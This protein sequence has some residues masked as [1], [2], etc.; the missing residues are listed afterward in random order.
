M[1]IALVG[2]PG[3]GK[4][5]VAMLLE[6]RGFAKLRFGDITDIELKRRGLE[7]NEHNEKSLREELRKNYGMSAYAQLLLPLIKEK[8]A[9][10]QHNIVL[11]GMRSYEEFVL[12]KNHFG[13]VLKVV[14]ISAPQSL[15]IKRL[16]KRKI[17][18]LTEQEVKS[19]DHN[20]LN[21]LNV[22]KTI[23]HAD[24]RINNTGN[25]RSLSKKV[26]KTLAE[27]K[28]RN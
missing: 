5:T 2:L 24:Y 11:D 10:K 7:I 3:S 6:K 8:I 12:L 19:R 9:R 14:M 16:G 15:R 1:I 17:R 13:K 18:P 25:L 27:I 28:N 21:I 23:K 4:G 22:R 20:E 26:E